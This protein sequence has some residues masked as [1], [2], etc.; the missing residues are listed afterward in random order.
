[1]SP[2]AW[3]RA[4][5]TVRLTLAMLFVSLGPLAAA[6]AIVLRLIEDSLRRQVEARQAQLAAVAST[7]VLNY[8]ERARDKL[9]SISTIVALEPAAPPRPPGKVQGRAYLSRLSPEELASRLNVFI[10][11]ADVFHTLSYRAVDEALSGSTPRPSPRNS[12]RDS[13][14]SCENGMSGTS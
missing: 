14:P 6:G 4:R 1:V 3:I 5:L 9:R 8:V 7:F 12:R 13:R 10:Q 11:P 2:L